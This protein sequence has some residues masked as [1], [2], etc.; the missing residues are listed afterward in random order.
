M[1]PRILFR[2]RSISLIWKLLIPFL[3]FAFIGTTSLVYLGLNSQQT[4]IAEENTREMKKLYRLFLYDI[5]QKGL[6]VLGMASV[7]AEDPKVKSFIGDRKR[8]ELAAYAIPV[9]KILKKRFGVEQFHFHIPPGRSFLRLHRESNQGEMMPYRRTI[10]EAM[11]TGKG[12]AGLEW[13][14]PDWG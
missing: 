14:G 1:W 8:E 2:I 3:A 10:W 12:V 5:K 4:L 13:G 11:K 6:E 7:I 9:F